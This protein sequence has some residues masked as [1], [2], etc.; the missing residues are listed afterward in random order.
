[1][2]DSLLTPDHCVGNNLFKTARAVSRIYAEEMHPAGLARSQF[3]ILGALYQAGP[4][5]L[6][7]LAERLY[8][9]RTTLTRNLRP[10]ERDGFVIRE[11]APDDGRIRLVRLTTAGRD[12]FR[13]AKGY[14]QIAQKRLLELLGKAEWTELEARL[15]ALRRQVKG[16]E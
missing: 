10:L 13:E 2:T 12:K 5:S 7:A 11:S 16:N 4:I 14:W 9:D 6:S 3:S 15:V 8:M 1:M